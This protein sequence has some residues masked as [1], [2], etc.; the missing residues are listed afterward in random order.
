M[1]TEAERLAEREAEDAFDALT[2][3]AGNAVYAAL[4]EAERDHL[5]TAIRQAIESMDSGDEGDDWLCALGNAGHWPGWEGPV[6]DELLRTACV[7]LARAKASPWTEPC[8]WERLLN[9]A[10]GDEGE[11]R[12]DPLYAGI[13]FR[14]DRPWLTEA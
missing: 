14:T 10:F 6:T 3:E 7:V 13:P 4:T 9:G 8:D 2:E 5:R 11:R 12:L 1:R